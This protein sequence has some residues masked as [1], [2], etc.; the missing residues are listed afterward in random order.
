MTDME[1]VS[2]ME[3]V[4]GYARDVVALVWHDK[5]GDDDVRAQ[6]TVRERDARAGKHDIRLFAKL[7]AFGASGHARAV[8]SDPPDQWPNV[9]RIAIVTD[10]AISRHL[11][12]FFAP[13]F[14]AAVKVFPNAQSSQAR[15]WLQGRKIG[16]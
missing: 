4:P 13:F 2:M 10:D 5:L 12:Q 16:P 9:G 11:V 1:S 14:H 7:T 15:I 8:H 6:M 3:V